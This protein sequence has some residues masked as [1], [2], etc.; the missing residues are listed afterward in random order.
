MCL[1]Y[2]VQDFKGTDKQLQQNGKKK[3]RELWH[4]PACVKHLSGG[5]A[6]ALEIAALDRRNR[7]PESSCENN[8]LLLQLV[9]CISIP[10]SFQYKDMFFS[11]VTFQL[12]LSQ[13]YIGQRSLSIP[14]SLQNPNS[15]FS[16]S[17]F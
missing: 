8:A 9:L 10:F 17:S 7:A 11:H 13:E 1:I 5:T 12:P 16:P 3:Q 2:N 15:W 6:G 14:W 4:Q